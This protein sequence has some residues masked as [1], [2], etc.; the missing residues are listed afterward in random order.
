M[1]P[2]WEQKIEAA[3]KLTTQLV[4]GVAML[5]IPYGSET[6]QW[7][8]GSCHDCAVEKGQ[9][10]VPGC[11]VEQCPACGGQIISCDCCEVESWFN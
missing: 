5:R 4:N 11:D 9:L 7:G 8:E 3:Q 1:I 10:H 6:Q 2:E